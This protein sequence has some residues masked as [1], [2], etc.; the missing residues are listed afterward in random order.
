VKMLKK[1][2]SSLWFSFATGPTLKKTVGPAPALHKQL[3]WKMSA[4][5]G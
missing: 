2:P 1:N 5:V 3:R 4:C